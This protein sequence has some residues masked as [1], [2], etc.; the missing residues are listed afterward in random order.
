[1]TAKQL[2][3]WEQRRERLSSMPGCGAGLT[4]KGK[5]G[6]CRQ[7]PPEVEAWWDG[8][9]PALLKTPPERWYTLV[10]ELRKRARKEGKPDPRDQ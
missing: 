6:S 9:Y 8:V 4:G 5:L 10:K 1:M 7:K 2:V 3:A